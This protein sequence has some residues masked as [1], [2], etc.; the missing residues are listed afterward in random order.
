MSLTGT[1][2]PFEQ[3]YY[4]LEIPGDPLVSI[5]V[6]A[7]V[8]FTG[9]SVCPTGLKPS[10]APKDPEVTVTVSASGCE[11]FQFVFRLIT[12]R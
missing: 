1:L 7:N 8:S 5:T 11:V 10:F 3:D 6:Q 2:D 12:Q 4:Q 9:D